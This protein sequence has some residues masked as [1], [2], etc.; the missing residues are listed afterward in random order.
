MNLE[1]RTLNPQRMNWYYAIEGRSHGPVDAKALADLARAGRLDGDTLIWHPGLTEWEPATRLL[2]EIFASLVPHPG[3]ATIEKQSAIPV[4]AKKPQK[5]KASESGG[6][7][8]KLF[9]SP[10]K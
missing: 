10:K 4:A 2:P 5:P 3:P 1:P 6:L 8:K 7:L 9:G